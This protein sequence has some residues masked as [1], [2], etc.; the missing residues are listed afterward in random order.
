MEWRVRGWTH[1]PRHLHLAT[2]SR[3][4]GGR[5]PSSRRGTEQR[6]KTRDVR[7]SHRI[8][9]DHG[10]SLRQSGT[11]ALRGSIIDAADEGIGP[12]T[13]EG[14]ECASCKPGEK[15]VEHTVLI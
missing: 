6:A 4:N 5:A 1:V 13:I 10:V 12:D 8:G 14:T 2:R 9:S 11:D 3:K 15:R 7:L